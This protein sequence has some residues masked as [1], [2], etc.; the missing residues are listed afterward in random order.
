LIRSDLKPIAVGGLESY[1]E[2]V[3]GHVGIPS[4]ALGPILQMLIASRLKFVV[5]RGSKVRYR[6]ARLISYSLLPMLSEDDLSEEAT[7]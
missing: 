6:S 2:R 5:L 4:D 1:P 7:D 3:D